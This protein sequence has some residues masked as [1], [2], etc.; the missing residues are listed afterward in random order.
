MLQ[1]KSHLIST[2][3]NLTGAGMLLLL[4]ASCSVIPRNYPANRPF[5]YETNIKI[6]GN[7]SKDERTILVSQLKTQLDDSVK[8]RTVGKLL[9]Q[10]LKN[11]PAYD[12]VNADKSVNFMKALLH[13]L[14]YLRDT[15]TYDTLVVIKDA[16]PPQYRTT[17]NFYVKPGKLFRLDSISYNIEHP[18]LQVLTLAE[19]KNT[20]LKKG[21]AFSKYTISAELDRLT[22]IYR[23]NGYLR[24]TKDELIGYWDTLDVA[25]L[26]PTIDFSEQILLLQ[27]LEKRRENPT[28]NIEIRFKPGFDTSKLKKFYVGYTTIYP[29]FGSDTSRF[30]I[31][32]ITVRTGTDIFYR[33]NLF[34]P[35]FLVDN[36]YFQ[37][38]DLYVQKDFLRTI[39][40]FN[41]LGAWKLVNIEQVPRDDGS[42]TVDFNVFLTPS[43]KY[44]FTANI[45]GS[46][47]TG[48]FL[49]EG[50]LLGLG[51]NL[52]LVN[53]NFGRTANQATTT[54]RYG[55]ELGIDSQFVQ[56]RQVSLS[57]SIYFPKPIP[58]SKL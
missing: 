58:N 11:P 37:Q 53:R 9:T 3:L 15:I 34:R 18:E 33:R 55:T 4:A 28:A 50:S 6:E 40:R 44:S 57:H 41:A 46:R 42:D 30:P 51:G 38:G 12:S 23:D 14:G 27:A 47:N 31:K 13:S 16:E 20:L 29:D 56:T 24:F 48:Q 10:V 21:E 52:Q 43:N 8:V 7:F 49:S 36:L 22:E 39:N 2:F 17:L 19:V 5:V 1:S 54:F 25:L 26:R 45:E 32:K 35:K